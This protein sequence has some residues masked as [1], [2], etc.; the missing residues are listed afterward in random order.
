MLVLWITW[1]AC[2]PAPLDTDTSLGTDTSVGSDTDTASDSGS[3]TDTD[4]A[5][6]TDSG[7]DTQAGGRCTVAP[8]RVSC[9]HEVATLHA[10]ADGA[11]ERVLRW[12]IPV[13]LPPASGWPAVVL[14]QGSLTPTIGYWDASSSATYGMY[15]GAQ[16]TAE[17]LDRG[18]AVLT[19]EARDNGTAWWDTNIP[20][21]TTSWT[22]APDHFL[23]LDLLAHIDAGDYG[24]IDTDRLFASGISSGGFM[25]S[26]MAASY[27]GRFRALA[28]QSA[29]WATC[30]STWCVVPT[31]PEDHPPTLLLH[32][33]LD[34][35]VPVWMM[36]AYNL[37]LGEAGI[38]HDTVTAPALGHQWL[39]EAPTA[40]ADWFDAHR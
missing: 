32:G 12:Q 36:E 35:V 25:T 27:A 40:V 24:G 7:T 33:Q 22:T 11:E 28:V 31:L 23:M 14:F 15:Y 9:T 37:R 18:Y 20:P 39:P 2:T 8:A 34:A 4:P 17:L 1:M 30:G 10:G 13:G 21:Y 29:S 38:E 16:L 19:P 3:V 26:R 6:G 5:T